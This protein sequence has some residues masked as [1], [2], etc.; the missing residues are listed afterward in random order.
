MQTHDIPSHTTHPANTHTP[1][2][3]YHKPTTLLE[4]SSVPSFF[5][6]N[7]SNTSNTSNLLQ[8]SHSS[9]RPDSHYWS[10][11]T[12]HP[13]PPHNISP[14]SSVLHQPLTYGRSNTALLT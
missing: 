3:T 11:I 7:T 9:L 14:P 12:S 1:S 6:H 4:L 10:P 8:A 13:A 5:L 2:P